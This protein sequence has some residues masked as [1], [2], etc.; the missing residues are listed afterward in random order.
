MLDNYGSKGGRSYLINLYGKKMETIADI[1]DSSNSKEYKIAKATEFLESLP[2]LPHLRG[3]AIDISVREDKSG[4][5][6]LIKETQKYANLS[7]LDE[8]NHF[9]ITVKSLESGEKIKT[10]SS[11]KVGPYLRSQRINKLFK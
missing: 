9:H 5:L 2:P 6:N 8:G 3:D 7:V 11:S 1:F 10:F 4:I